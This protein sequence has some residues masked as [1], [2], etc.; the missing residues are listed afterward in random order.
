MKEVILQSGSLFVK[1]YEYNNRDNNTL[2]IAKPGYGKT[3]LIKRLIRKINDANKNVKFL[4]FCQMNDID[5]KYDNMT[6]SNVIIKE[7]DNIEE[8]L[9]KIITKQREAVNKKIHKKIVFVFDDCFGAKK[10]PQI[11][12]EMILNARPY[13][14]NIIMSMQYPFGLEP[15]IR[16]N[17]D[18]VFS[19]RDD[20][21][22]NLKKIYDH[23]FGIFPSHDIFNKVYTQLTEDYG[24]MVTRDKNDTADYVRY[25]N[26]RDNQTLLFSNS[27][28]DE[29]NCSES[30]SQSSCS[31]CSHDSN[32]SDCKHEY[33]KLN[34]NESDC[35]INES[36][37]DKKIKTLRLLF[38]NNMNIL[39]AIDKISNTMSE[40]NKIELIDNLLIMNE[41][42]INML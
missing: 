17:F 18:V 4:V 37:T 40:I 25:Y 9:E 22:P 33:I 35:S 6:E 12:K 14:I 8:Q 31:T 36:V 7:T 24:F 16:Q 23:Y 21:I 20:Y 1:E 38:E 41:Q 27:T 29:T 13:H 26:S 34:N 15:A 28:D 2:I 39:E 11:F 10:M 5:H 3:T 19:G 30:D 42:I 32:E